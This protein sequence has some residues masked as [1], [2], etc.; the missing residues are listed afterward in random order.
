MKTLGYTYY[1]PQA[2]EQIAP[3]H[4]D[5]CLNGFSMCKLKSNILNM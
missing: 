1:Q 3:E 4:G 5:D 2:I